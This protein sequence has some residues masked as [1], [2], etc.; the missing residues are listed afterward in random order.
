[1]LPQQAEIAAATL[2]PRYRY[3]RVTVAGRTALLVLGD[4]DEHRNG[5]VEVWYSAQREVLRIQNG[6]IA[7]VTGLRTEWRSV[8]MPAMPA[9][10]TLASAARQH[11]WIRIRDVMPGYRFGVRDALILSRIS[12][13]AQSALQGLDPAQL[14]W[15]EER[16]R[17][18]PTSELW[19]PPARYAVQI[20]EGRETVVYGE[21]CIARDLC[22]TWQRWPV[23]SKA[24]TGK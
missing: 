15:F 4:M 7:G 17:G 18:D 22:F 11:H 2:N 5:Q 20:G 12:T 10:S 1:V 14:A 13:P 9:W 23:E 16:H 19:L 8:S 3:L 21:Q 6:R 24:A